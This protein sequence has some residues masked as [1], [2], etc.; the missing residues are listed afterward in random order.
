MSIC[1]KQAKA[2]T[3]STFPHGPNPT[4][5]RR[6]STTSSLADTATQ[7]SQSRGWWVGAI[8]MGEIFTCP[9]TASGWT[10]AAGWT[11]LVA[12]S[13]AA[14]SEETGRAGGGSKKKKKNQRCESERWPVEVRVSAREV[15][16]L[17]GDSARR[18]GGGGRRGWRRRPWGAVGGGER[19][20]TTR[21]WGQLGF[22]RVCP[23]IRHVTQQQSCSIQRRRGCTSAPHIGRHMGLWLFR[24]SSPV[25]ALVTGKTHMTHIHTGGRFY[26]E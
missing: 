5:K 23:P 22:L 16:Y 11:K 13:L 2:S 24:S 6:D 18:W 9:T 20:G 4:A 8:G 12:A 26:A 1:T 3:H 14:P 10:T 21:R 17:R 7:L 19:G 15:A 25:H